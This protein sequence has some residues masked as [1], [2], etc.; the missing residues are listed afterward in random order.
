VDFGAFEIKEEKGK[1]R[2]FIQSWAKQSEVC[3][4]WCE[5]SERH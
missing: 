4:S 1:K 3:A 5:W 2:L